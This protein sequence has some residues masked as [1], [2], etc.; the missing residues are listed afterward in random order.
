MNKYNTY[1]VPLGTY[2]SAQF[3]LQ[4]GQDQETKEIVQVADMLH[5]FE[6]SFIYEGA[7]KPAESITIRDEKSIRALYNLLAV[8]FDPENKV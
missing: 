1:V 8:H 5:I 6:A 4:E 2:S 3:Q 7:Y